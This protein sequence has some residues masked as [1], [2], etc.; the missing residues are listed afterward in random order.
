M[1]N[2]ITASLNHSNE[3]I[4][5]ALA[6]SATRGDDGIIYCSSTGIDPERVTDL[7]YIVLR[8]SRTNGL[9]GLFIGRVTQIVR[10]GD[11]GMEAML[12]DNRGR[13]WDELTTDPAIALRI[14]GFREVCAEDRPAQA[15]LDFVG[16]TR[17]RYDDAGRLDIAR[18]FPWS[19]A[20]TEDRRASRT[21]KNPSSALIF[22]G[23]DFASHDSR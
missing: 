21:L 7:Q 8:R 10:S 5:R 22:P 1:A 3:S 20:T 12:A 23:G 4:A 9:N 19:I 11:Q 17:F 14:V 2:V 6:F 16:H 18:L 15:L 13:P